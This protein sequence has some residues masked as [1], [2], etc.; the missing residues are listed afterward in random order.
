MKRVLFFFLALLPA[1]GLYAYKFQYGDLYYNIT[2]DSTVE[3]TYQMLSVVGIGNEDNYRGLASANIPISVTYNDAIYTVTSI[4]D[5]AFH[6]CSSLSSITIP[7]SITSIGY[8]AFDGCTG[9]TSITI[10][11]SIT[12]IGDSAFRGCTGLTNVNY[13]G[14]INGWLDIDMDD[15]RLS[16]YELHFNG[17]LLTEWVISEGIT[18]ISFNF[19]GC[20]SLTSVTIPTSVTS[21]E[22]D[23]F[24]GCI[25]LTSITIPNSVTSIGNN[26]FGGV[27]NVVY[28]GTATGSPWGAKSVNGYVDDYFVYKDATKT[29]LLGCSAAA[30]GAI[31]IPNSVTSIGGGAFS[32]CTGLTSITIPNSVTSIGY[33]AFRGC[34]GLTNV[35]YTGTINGWLDIDMDDISLSNYELHF[36][37]VLLTEC[38]ISEG[39]TNISFHF[40]GCKSLTSIT[41]PNSV[42]SIG[43]S[44]FRGCTGLTSI[45]IPNSV[46]SIGNNAFYGCTGLTS[47]T[48]GNSVTSIGGDAFYGCTGIAS[49]VWNV[50][51]YEDFSYDQWDGNSNNPLY[52]VRSQIKSFVFGDSVVTI[53]AYICYK[54][55]S[56]TSVTIGSSVTSIG[57]N[58]FEGCTNLTSIVWNAKSYEDFSFDPWNETESN[59]PF[60][61][62]RSQIKSF[63]FGDSVVT[64]PEAMC[65][66]MDSLTSISFG[67][68]ITKIG[69]CALQGCSNLQSVYWNVALG[70]SIT[71][72]F[73]GES[74]FNNFDLRQQIT[75]F[76]F[77]EDVV[78]IPSFL[79]KGMTKL[80]SITIGKNVHK[81]DSE[82]FRGCDSLKSVHFQGTLSDWANID[83]EGYDIQP[84]CYG[85]DEH[86]GANPLEYADSLFIDNSYVTD[87]TI[88]EGVTA[89]KRCAFFG[90]AGL[91]S[92]KLPNSLK[93]IG[94]GAFYGCTSLTSTL[95]LPNVTSIGQWAFHSIG[96]HGTLNIPHSVT[97][98]GDAAFRY[99]AGID[100]LIIG[101]GIAD[102]NNQFIGC[103]GITYL[104]LGSGVKTLGSW[105]FDDSEKL[106]R[107][108]C[109]AIEP[110]ASR[111]GSFY[112]YN[113]H[114]QVPCDNLEDYETDAVW[115]SFKYL[116]CV[117]AE[118]TET[119][120]KVLVTPRD[121]DA[122]ITWPT[123]S[124]AET[125]TIL[126]TQDGTEICTLIFNADGQLTRIAFS[127]PSRNGE[128]RRTPAAL[129]TQDGYRFTVTGLSSATQYAYAIDVKDAKSNVLN[130][131]KGSFTTTGVVTGFE[132]TPATDET[133]GSDAPRKVFRDGQV[134]ILR[135]GKTYTLTG[136]E[137]K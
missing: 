73:Y 124:N 45:T 125:Y 63:V 1:M 94:D 25:G 137:V 120:G 103:D 67:R 46:T 65:Y 69:K 18:N 90:Y 134:Y 30:T 111:K 35:N 133:L 14:T 74:Y 44:A 95:S 86:K 52:T 3:V 10:P 55:D 36:N 23:A 88:P 51:S 114:V 40:K 21:I 56:L 87:I 97:S 109:Y 41:I 62:I 115:G 104:Q 131:Y 27:F 93:E 42:T 80:L 127:A 106:K 117:G 6:D 48:I 136:V 122:D 77:G 50:K 130:T 5:F 53:P 84:N 126:I 119:N 22:D 123:N 58:V 82:V 32:G 98:L 68:N 121:N 102:I 34:S 76:I 13:T 19:K 79:C 70:D 100:T 39:I 4:G 17:V 101:N 107:I 81:I 16:N 92:L 83:F 24:S 91:Q 8:I 105:A 60:Y 38:V 110:P 33:S 108:V 64:V 99:C 59:N 112:N 113:I 135:G 116:E 37:G 66:K 49:I 96:I 89:I 28:N 26:A 128:Q 43:H 75:A 85:C 11:N 118:K 61:D 9:L 12:S 20:K 57:N 78:S 29:T 2:S 7:K 71:S 31:I 129:L 15:I 54:M 132:E 47:I 72:P